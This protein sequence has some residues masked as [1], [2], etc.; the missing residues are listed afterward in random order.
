L[1]LSTHVSSDPDSFGDKEH[2]RQRERSPEEKSKSNIHVM[3]GR[4]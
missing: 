2:Q 3:V 1:L 4:L